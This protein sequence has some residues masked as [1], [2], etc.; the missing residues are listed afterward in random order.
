MSNHAGEFAD[1]PSRSL[2]KG[3]L[4]GL[5]AGLAGTVAMTFAERMFPPHS[6]GRPHPSEQLADRMESL[7]PRR[8]SW[9]GVWFEGPA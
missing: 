4:A 9:A 8:T 5:A 7:T 6:D 2:G 3:L 1:Q